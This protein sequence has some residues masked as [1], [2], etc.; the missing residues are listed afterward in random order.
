M[1]KA[2]CPVCHDEV[3]IVQACGAVNYFCNTCNELKSSKV[4]LTE[5][6]NK[7]ARVEDKK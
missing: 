6:E 7:K 1:K 5:E 2:F 3:E 4:V